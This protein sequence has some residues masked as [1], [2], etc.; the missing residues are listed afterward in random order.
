MP[1]IR[2]PPARAATLR[3][4]SGPRCHGGASS[5]LRPGFGATAQR[6]ASTPAQR[7]ERAESDADAL[8]AHVV[9][10]PARSERNAEL[11]C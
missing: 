6:V 1:S 7:R 3:R 10:W 11:G 8:V 5:L 9:G 4:P 2:R